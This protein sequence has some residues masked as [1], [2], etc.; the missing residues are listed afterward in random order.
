MFIK[1][2]SVFVEN[3]PGRLAEI[4]EIISAAGCN[5]LALS[6]ADTTSFGI[7]RLIVDDPDKVEA[8]I[9]ENN[10]TVSFTTV[11]SLKI[12]DR[13]GGLTEALSLLSNA[14]I[15]VAYMYAFISKADNDAAQVVLKVKDDEIAADIL[16]K[17]GF[18][19]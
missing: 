8:A 14:G 3:K 9:K 6:I 19:L 17:N 4:T 2:I 12:E 16:A 1:Q 10:I 13:P 15:D 5:I 11:I 18:K 7:L